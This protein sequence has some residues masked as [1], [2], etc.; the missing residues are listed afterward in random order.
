MLDLDAAVQLEEV[1]VA[2]VEHELDGAGAAVADRAA[3][4]DRG[5]A[6]SRS[7]LAVER[8]GG[9]LL[10]HLLVPALDR[11]VALAEGDD[12]AVL[13][14][15]QLDLDVTRPLDVALVVDGVVAEGGLR[16]AAGRLGRLL[17]LGRLADDAHPAAAS[18]GGRLDDEREADLVR[19][20]GREHRYAGLLRDPLRLELVAALA[21]RVRRRPDEDEP[22][23]LDRLGE[24]G[25]LGEEAVPRMD[26]V[27]ADALGGAD[28][29]LR[30]EVALDLDRLV[31]ESRVEGAAVVGRGDGDGRD[32]RVGAGAEDPRRDLA[33]V[34]YEELLGSP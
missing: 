30:E 28:V 25:V 23:G 17:E 1:E 2:P 18:A 3:E 24:V 20:A 33:A 32:P 13:V 31:R 29:L 8:G 16:L 7:E 14:R 11:A 15:E 10:E 5:L 19:L 6:H 4:R 34:R 22:G 12:L 21:Q 27:R 26:R 9:R